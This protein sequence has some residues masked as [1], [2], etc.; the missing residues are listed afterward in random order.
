MAWGAAQ[1][2]AGHLPHNLSVYCAIQA[3]DI[4]GFDWL[5]VSHVLLRLDHDIDTM[6]SI[7]YQLYRV[8][9]QLAVFAMRSP[10]GKIDVVGMSHVCHRVMEHRG[11]GVP[12]SRNMTENEAYS[13]LHRAT[14]YWQLTHYS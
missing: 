11:E 5:P 13:M 10:L 2:G 6:T 12:E 8:E 14:S 3:K 7:R 9:L 4:P 1:R